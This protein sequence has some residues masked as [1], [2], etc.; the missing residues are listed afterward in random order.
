MGSRFTLETNIDVLWK[1]LGPNKNI[2][3]NYLIVSIF[4]H[5]IFHYYPQCKFKKYQKPQANYSWITDATSV[6][7]W[8]KKVSIYFLPLTLG[9]NISRE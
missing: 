2:Q 6:Q 3:V 7:F 5:D 8:H 1:T 9:G 4:S